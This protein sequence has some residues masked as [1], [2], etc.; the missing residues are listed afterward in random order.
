MR[1]MGF[2]LLQIVIVLQVYS[3]GKVCYVVDVHGYL[4]EG[5]TLLCNVSYV[6]QNVSLK[7][8]WHTLK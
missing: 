2:L 6:L 4:P 5:A 7:P 8:N 3:P 1:Y